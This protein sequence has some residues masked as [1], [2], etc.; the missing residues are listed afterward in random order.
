MSC[1]LGAPS[2]AFSRCWCW[3]RP[4]LAAELG[5]QIPTGELASLEFRSTCGLIVFNLCF[6]RCV[7]KVGRPEPCL[8][9]ALLSPSPSPH[10]SG[11]H[12]ALPFCI[13]VYVFPSGQM[14]KL[15]SREGK[16]P[17]WGHTAHHTGTK[18]ASPIS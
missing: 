6:Q 3:M 18:P 2:G 10:S 1:L 16:W 8:A 4:K 15:G 5:L 9:P 12:L 14:N 7:G 17:V 13:Q 11:L